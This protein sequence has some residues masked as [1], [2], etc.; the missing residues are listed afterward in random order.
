LLLLVL[1]VFLYRPISEI[2]F[3]RAA[4]SVTC[5]LLAPCLA[6]S[7]TWKRERVHSSNTSLNF[8]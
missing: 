1:S 4:H 3:L 2:S 8:Y 7:S 6:H 5:F